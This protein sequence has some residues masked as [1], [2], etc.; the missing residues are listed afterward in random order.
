MAVEDFAAVVIRNSNVMNPLMRIT[1]VREMPELIKAC[2]NRAQEMLAALYRNLGDPH[3]LLRHEAVIQLTK[4]AESCP[5]SVKRIA[6]TLVKM[7]IEAVDVRTRCV[8][9]EC[10]LS[11]MHLWP[12]RAKELADGLLSWIFGAGPRRSSCAHRLLGYLIDWCPDNAARIAEIIIAASDDLR[13]KPNK[14]AIVHL[15]RAARICPDKIDEIVERLLRYSYRS[16][17][18]LVREAAMQALAAELC[19]SKRK[20]L[21]VPVLM[22]CNN[23]SHLVRNAAVGQL[24]P[25]LKR[26]PE[27]F[28]EVL[29][30]LVQRS[31][32]RCEADC[33]QLDGSGGQCMSETGRRD[34]GCFALPLRNIRPSSKRTGGGAVGR[35]TENVSRQS[36]GCPRENA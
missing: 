24:G 9:A 27:T 16:G 28:N 20:D 13:E 2:P 32:R 36:D 6:S 33:H 22:G 35:V 1:A 18:S 4:S 3:F 15:A 8:A 25:F 7:W 5:G 11:G 14:D 34:C 21:A 19:P 17:E 31:S 23:R 29:A 12:E 30:A 26:C 10:L